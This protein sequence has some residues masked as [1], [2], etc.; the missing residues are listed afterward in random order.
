VSGSEI[1]ENT[2]YKQKKRDTHYCFNQNS[3]QSIVLK[4]TL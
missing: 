3:A 1:K 4:E 2:E